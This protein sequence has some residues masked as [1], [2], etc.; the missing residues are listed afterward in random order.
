M[1][2]NKINL[3][4]VDDEEQFLASIS[5]SLQVRDFNVTAVNRGEKA[6]EAARNSKFDVALVDLKMPG[7]NGEETLRALKKEHKWME[8]VI[9]T[10]HGSVRSA[11]DMMKSGA[12]EY[13]QKPC[14]LEELLTALKNAYQKKVMNRKDID[15]DRMEEMLALSTAESPMGIL[16]ILNRLR[17]I[18][19]G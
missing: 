12:Y 8:V 14:N 3:L 18:D 2:D 9:L 15:A 5:K 1:T 13:L 7:M 11:V 6:I 16:A 10:G 17:E 19:K 4:I